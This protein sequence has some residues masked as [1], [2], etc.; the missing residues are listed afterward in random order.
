VFTRVRAHAA[1][2]MSPRQSWAPVDPCS[3]WRREDERLTIGPPRGTA[4][5]RARLGFV[6]SRVWR[7]S[8]PEDGRRRA[9]G[10]KGRGRHGV[11][12][13]D[14]DR[15]RQDSG[16]RGG[17]R[18]GRCCLLQHH[19]IGGRVGMTATGFRA[20]ESLLT[21][22]VRTRL[23]S[24][25]D[26]RTH[27]TVAPTGAGGAEEQQDRGGQCAKTGAAAS[28]PGPLTHYLLRNHGR[29][30][31]STPRAALVW[32]QRQRDGILVART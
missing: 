8:D 31:P 25:R 19:G 12:G 22:I 14:L 3:D 17:E 1:L 10:G 30:Y 29:R 6:G 16:A 13:C 9:V 18:H 24:C 28:R 26:G 21:A 20:R 27:R 23:L 32:K 11:G 7:P 4:D 5:A 15:C 2:P